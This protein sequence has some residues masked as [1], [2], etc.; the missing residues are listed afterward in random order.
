MR[1]DG[2]VFAGRFR[3]DRELGRGPLATSFLVTDLKTSRACVLKRLLEADV[4]AADARIFEAQAAVLA[5]LAHPGLPAFVDYIVEDEGA[6]REHLLVTRYFPGESLERLVGKGRL[7]TEPQALALL[8]RLAPVFRYLHGFDPPLVH[9][10]LKASNVIV[11]PDARPCLVDFHFA[12]EGP[13]WRAWEGTPE[14]ADEP[15]IVAPEAAAG[16]AVPASDIYVLGVALVY[17]M[18]GQRPGEVSGDAARARLR[19]TLRIGD[20]FAAILAR[21]VEPAL[22]RRY[23]DV[24]ALEADLARVAAGRAPGAPAAQASREVAP[25]PRQGPRRSIAGVVLIAVVVAALAVGGYSWWRTARAPRPDAESLTVTAPGAPDAQQPAPPAAQPSAEP[26][27]A[28]AQTDV[29]APAPPAAPGVAEVPAS[30]APSAP[31]GAA[32]AAPTPPAPA[33]APA[34]APAPAPAVAPVAAPAPPSAPPAP[35][36]AAPAPAAAA[37]DATAAPDAAEVVLKGRLL[38]DGQPVAGTALPEPLFWFRDDVKKVQVAPRVAYE[39]GAFTVRGLAPGKYGLSVRVDAQ[40][41]NPNIFPGDLNAWAEFT[42]EAGRVATVEMPLRRIMRLQQPVDNAVVLPGWDVPCGAGYPSAGKILF[43]WEPVD[44]AATYEVRV[45]RL[46]CGRGYATAGAAFS[47]STTDPWVN[48]EL[49]PSREG[50]CYSFRLSAK[51]GGQP[52]GILA[53]HGKTGLGWDYRF[54]VK[55]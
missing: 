52:I 29:A 8:G 6:G 17:A 53:T 40:K 39:A 14:D 4:P 1:G 41:S 25:E 21:M 19:E 46:L 43:A 31:E 50:E 18:S 32:P 54:V 45:D 49:P 10:L 37:P 23:P 20:A 48:V 55:P 2:R 38:F 26:G 16:G 11:G 24:R 7:L 28:P 9:R 13:G 44:P 42:V 27:A 12:V 34:S 36:P 51:K 5:K 33:P 30:A 35:A 15:P 47:K 22:E 3:V